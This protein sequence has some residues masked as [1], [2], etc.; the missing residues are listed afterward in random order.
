MNARIVNF[1]TIFTSVAIFMI[2]TGC[3]GTT[4]PL[5]TAA[6]DGNL[7]W[8]KALID[9][10]K[11]DVNFKGD[12]GYTAL[13]WAAYQGYAPIAQVLIERGALVNPVDENGN[14]PLLLATQRGYVDVVAVLIAHG[15]DVNVR[16]KSNWTPL[17]YAAKAGNLEIVKALVG[18]AA[19]VNYVDLKTGN[20]A[21][22][23]A[24][25]YSRNDVLD[26]LT[27]KDQPKANPIVPPGAETVRGGTDPKY[28]NKPTDDTLIPKKV[29]AVPA[30]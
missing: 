20:N 24:R 6:K 27:G 26:F 5:S 7:E 30:D 29:N 10:K 11:A 12:Y 9:D 18:A 14:T 13:H 8:V 2:V 23:L 16:D 28:P 21:M 22:A 25:S 15:A 19:D 1:K 4:P 3:G 17:F